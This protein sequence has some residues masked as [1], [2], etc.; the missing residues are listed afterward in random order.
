MTLSSDVA[1]DEPSSSLLL[2][3][4]LGY[5]LGLGSCLLYTPIAVRVVRQ[6]HADGLTLSTWW[7]KLC[8]Y[9][10]SDVYYIAKQY[11]IS[12]YIETL[13]ITA[14]A[15]IILLL[16]WGTIKINFQMEPLYF[17]PSFTWQALPTA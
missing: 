11:P 7:L 9:T 2:A 13:I 17:A 12:T 6:G 3:N 10:C 15:A 4:A 5:L 1:L 8:S 14:Q 16:V